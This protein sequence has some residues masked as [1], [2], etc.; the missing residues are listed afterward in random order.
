M[1]ITDEDDIY[2]EMYEDQR[3]LNSETDMFDAPQL[4]T[5]ITRIKTKLV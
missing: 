2:K 1:V 4:V 3:R 5:I